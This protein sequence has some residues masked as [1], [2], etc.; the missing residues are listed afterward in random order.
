MAEKEA[1]KTIIVFKKKKGKHAHHGGAWKV[2]F[3]DFMTAMFALFLVLWILTQSQEVKEAVAS[4]FRHPTDYEGTP[5]VFMRGNDGLMDH[6]QGRMDNDATVIEIESAGNKQAG[7]AGNNPGKTATSVSGGKGQLS[8]PEGL[9]PKVV[10]KVED[11]DEV[12]TFLELAEKLWEVL[13]T[14]SSFNKIKDNLLIQALEDGLLIQLLEQEK[15]PLFEDGQDVFKPAIRQAL[16]VVAK[17]LST[18]PNKMEIDGHGKSIANFYTEKQ[19]WLASTYIADL[20]RMEMERGGLKPQQIIR[21]SGCAD[22]RP[23]GPAGS[24]RISI[25]VR[26]RQWQERY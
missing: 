16:G 6:K 24:R 20:T 11:I 13:G 18:L 1:P 22:T 21:V 7:D 19:K 9:R 5:D 4:Y 12:R 23:M 25:L 17:E 3:A 10:S 8:P 14:T 2:A 15:S 26:P